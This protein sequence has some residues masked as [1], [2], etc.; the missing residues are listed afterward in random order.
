MSAPHDPST[1]VGFIG[2]GIMGQPMAL[3]LAR[4]G[5]SL[6]VWNRSAHSTEPLRAAGADVADDP[7]GVFAK[8]RIV[9]LMLRDEAAVDSVLRRHT[10]EFA[11][12]VRGHVVVQMGTMPPAF[13]MAL[14]ADIRSAGGFYVEAPVSGSR[15]PAETGRLVA[16]VAGDQHAVAAVTPL[17]APMCHEQFSCGAVPGALLMK[18]SVNIFLITMVTGL[19]EAV[20]FAGR[21][22]LDPAGVVDVL[23]A[24]PMASDVSRAK[25]AKLAAA[26]FTAQ[27]SITDVLKNTRLIVDAARAAGVATPSLDICHC[28]FGE[29][30]ELGAGS[31]DMIAVLRA[32]EARER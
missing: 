2:L 17:L 26:D 5:T 23:N 27:A 1:P 22:G 4:A 8:A 15:L 7:G 9:I 29:T 25:L 12:L 3:N 6:I 18:L 19:V 28:L 13:S 14:E 10:G 32:V 21:H 30:L 16:M 31:A 11:H 24:G 20:H